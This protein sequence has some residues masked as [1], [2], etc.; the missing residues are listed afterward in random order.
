MTFQKLSWLFMKSLK[1]QKTD[2]KVAL[3]THEE[4]KKDK[5]TDLL[6][7]VLVTHEEF[8]KDKKNDLLKVVL[9]T[10]EEF[11][12][13]KKKTDLLKVVLATHEEF[14]LPLRGCIWSYIPHTNCKK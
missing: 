12:K 5:K 7:V 6:K 8:K 1:R 3:A 11:K 13:T 9:A 14:Q 4:F 10:H 2:L